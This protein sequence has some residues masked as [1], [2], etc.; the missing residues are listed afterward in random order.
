MLGTKVGSALI[1]EQLTAEVGVSMMTGSTS[2]NVG[3]GV[4]PVSDTQ[5]LRRKMPAMKNK[6]K[7]VRL[8]GVSLCK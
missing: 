8:M 5:A 3:V 6:G 1:A 4:I 7:K 2:T